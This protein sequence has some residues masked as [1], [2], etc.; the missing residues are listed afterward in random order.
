MRTKRKEVIISSNEDL[1]EKV[2]I[3]S[4]DE[5]Q[6][7]EVFIISS[8]VLDVSIINLVYIKGFSF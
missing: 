3:T 8:N 5:D 1:K 4:S 7:K 2:I 6:K